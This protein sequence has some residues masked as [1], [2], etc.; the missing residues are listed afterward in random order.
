[1]LGLVFLFAIA[2]IVLAALKAQGASGGPMLKYLTLA[3]VAITTSAS[4][5]TIYQ[6]RSAAG[7]VTLQDAP[8][9]DDAKTELARKSIG[10]RNTEY[11]AEPISFFDPNAQPR[12]TSKIVCPS[13]RQSYQIALASSQRAILSNDP[14]QIQQASEAVQRA[15]AQVSKYRCE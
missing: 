7:K 13:L 15:G 2:V 4:A 8:C 10:Q 1:M 5:Q 9:P 11:R 6:C 14:G 12:L 3:I